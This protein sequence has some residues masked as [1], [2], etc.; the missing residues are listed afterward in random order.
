MIVNLE[1]KN[2]YNW[3][4]LILVI[5]TTIEQSSIGISLLPLFINAF[6]NGNDNFIDNE[7]ID[8]M[9]TGN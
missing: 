5:I 3:M 2:L 1:M 8:H 7:R 9:N 6:D 4:E